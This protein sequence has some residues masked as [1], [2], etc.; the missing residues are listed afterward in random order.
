MVKMLCSTPQAATFVASPE[1][2]ICVSLFNQF[3]F[4][5][6]CSPSGLLS[7]MRVAKHER[8]S[9]WTS[10]GVGSNDSKPKRKFEMVGSLVIASTISSWASDSEDRRLTIDPVRLQT[11]LCCGWGS[12]EKGTSCD[13]IV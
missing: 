13:S 11:R 1:S 10:V 4:S 7:S 12:F 9:F 3:S 8:I 6:I 2:L 5:E